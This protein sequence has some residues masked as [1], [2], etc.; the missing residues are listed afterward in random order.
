MII[1]NAI[2]DDLPRIMEIYA[3]AREYMAANGN[4][5][6]WGGTNWPPEDL[7]RSDISLG[8]S[9]VCE[10]AGKI[11]GVFFFDQGKD[12]EST[13]KVI[14][15]GTWIN[16]EPYGVIHRIASDGSIKGVGT[17]CFNWA[18]GQCSHLRADTHPDNKPMQ[19][20]LSRLGFEKRGIIH[21]VEDEYPRFAYEITEDMG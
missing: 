5:N 20:L 3:Y 9:Y 15:D 6:Q 4:P 18:R 13:Y 14:E 7:I 11:V 17:F 16:D 1:R 12:V 2:T 10:D 21:V 8:K 19:K